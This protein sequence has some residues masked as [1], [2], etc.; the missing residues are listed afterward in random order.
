MHMSILHAVLSPRHGIGILLGLSALVAGFAVVLLWDS[1][2]PSAAQRPHRQAVP[3]SANLALQPSPPTPRE[4]RSQ[5]PDPAPTHVDEF[6]PYEVI[7]NPDC[8]MRVGRGPAGDTA[9][10]VLPAAKGARFSV[11]DGNG[12]VFGGSLPFYPNHRKIG[13]RNGGAVVAAFG[14]LRLNGIVARPADSPEPVRVYV[15]GSIAYETTKAWNFDVAPDGTSFFLHE[16]VGGSGDSRLVLHNL[17]RGTQDVIDL[18]TMFAPKADH[19]SGYGVSYTNAGDEIVFSTAYEDEWGRGTHWFLAAD[20]STTRRVR[21]GDNPLDGDG[22]LREDSRNISLP[23]ARG[24]RLASSEE[25]YF[26][27]SDGDGLRVVRRRFSYELD[28]EP[29]AEVWSSRPAQL[30]RHYDGRIVLAANGAWLALPDWNLL[31]LDATTGK[32]L[33][34]YPK[35]GDKEAELARLASVLPQGA[36]LADVGGVGGVDFVDNDLLLFRKVGS[37][38]ACA[39]NGM[40]S[41]RELY[42]CHADLRRRGVYRRVA[43]IFHMETIDHFGQ[44]DAR[45]EVGPDIQCG[46]G[47]HPVRGLQTRQGRLTFLTKRA[48]LSQGRH[49]PQH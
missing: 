42:E 7:D 40:R 21:I 31:V 43:D 15:A 49:G 6:A 25:G 28:E 20:G 39:L 35:T 10:V 36:T 2:V 44:P 30:R 4:A 27:L 3:Q 17:D 8:R 13:K 11:V 32:T 29:V 16:P 37:N 46:A 48:R 45:I 23:A 9:I 5:T 38:A 24:A 1:E 22:T 26:V 33:F 19:W 47:D 18:G 41:R 14:D 34:E 12:E